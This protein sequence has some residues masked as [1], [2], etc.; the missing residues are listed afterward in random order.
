MDIY[1]Q[2]I[3]NEYNYGLCKI[4]VDIR[5]LARTFK[6][7]V[8]KHQFQNFCPWDL[9]TH[10]LQILIPTDYNYFL[11]KG[12]FFNPQKVK[13]D[14]SSERILPVHK[15]GFQETARPKD[16]QDWVLT[17]KKLGAQ[18]WIISIIHTYYLYDIWYRIL[19]QLTFKSWSYQVK[20]SRSLG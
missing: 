13:I 10:L 11:K 8:Q 6:M 7:P 12:F 15:E 17:I 16:R 1:L 5:F 2:K 18:N 9:A 4:K 3:S 19:Y 20:V 14:N